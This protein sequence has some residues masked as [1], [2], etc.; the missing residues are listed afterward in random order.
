[1]AIDMDKEMEASGTVEQRIVYE[2][3][4]EMAAYAAHQINS[5]IIGSLPIS[6]T[7]EGAQ[8]LD[9][10]KANDQHDIVLI[11]AVGEHVSAGVCYGA[12]TGGGRVFNAT[13]AN[14]YLYMLEQ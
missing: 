3:G 7:T 4:N 8:F 9:L 12:S 1:M 5:H 10:M 13:C 14:G 2:S 6:P 11:A